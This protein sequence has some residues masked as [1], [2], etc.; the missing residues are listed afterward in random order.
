MHFYLFVHVYFSLFM[1]LVS[2]CR[3]VFR[4]ERRFSLWCVSPWNYATGMQ[5]EIYVYEEIVHEL[6]MEGNHKSY[7]PCMQLFGATSCPECPIGFYCPSSTE[8]PIAC[9][10][11]SYCPAGSAAPQ[12]CASLFDATPTVCVLACRSSVSCICACCRHRH[13]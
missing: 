13:V 1:R 10:S 8:A 3:L 2:I 6:L 11:S 7:S 9:P 12:S 4:Y 5:S